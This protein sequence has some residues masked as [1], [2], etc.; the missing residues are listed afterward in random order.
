MLKKIRIALA[1]IFFIGITLLLAGIGGQWWGWMAKLQF[2]PSLLAGN[3]IVIAALCL[4]TFVF[5]RIYCSVICPL[6]VLQDLAIWLSRVTN[7]KKK[8]G[9]R[10]EHRILRYL[11]W[12]AY[13]AVL[14]AGVQAIVALFAPYSAYG[15]IVRSILAPAQGWLVPVVAGCTLVILVVLAWTQGREYCNSF[16]PVGTTLSF[17]SRFALFRPL[18]DQEMCVSCGS[19]GKACK[20]HCIDT[21]NKKIDYSRCVDCFDCIG[22]CKRG[23]VKYGFAYGKKKKAEAPAPDE[24]RRAFLGSAVAV[25]GALLASGITADAQRMKVDGGLAEVLPKQKPRRETPLVPPGAESVKDFYSHCTA[26][27]LCVANCPNKVLSPSTDFEHLMQPQMNYDKGFCR[28]ECTTC[29]QLCPAGAIKPLTPEEKTAVHIGHAVVDLDLCVVNR[30]GV[31]CGNC[32]AH[33]P[34][35]AIKMVRRDPEDEKSPR[36]PTVN[37]V[38]CI[39][40]GA[41]EYLC[42]ARPLSAIHIEGNSTHIFDE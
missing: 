17:F 8:F 33:C 12:A 3:F 18:L 27:Q 5:G 25:S 23:G 10:K 19:C 24:G 22:A 42:P 28:P 21:K 40:C 13:V 36:I 38:R 30:D 14:V 4:L 31:S 2:L 15:R 7:R 35:G 11:A 20:S 37:E 34:A 29:S 39:G 32:A 6:G 16:C 1:A 9:W 41:C 26:C